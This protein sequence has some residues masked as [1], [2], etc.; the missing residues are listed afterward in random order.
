M[1]RAARRDIAEG[2]IVEALLAIGAQVVRNLPTD[3]LVRYRGVLYL[4][5]VKTPGVYPDPRQ[6]AQR[7]FLAGW[8]VP[9]VKTPLAALTAIGVI[10]A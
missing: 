4:L 6:R 9:I 10:C 3:L 8:N 7:A 5:E 1:R 2:P